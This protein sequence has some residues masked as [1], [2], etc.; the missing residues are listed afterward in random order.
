MQRET[1]ERKREIDTEQIY[2]E[3][4]AKKPLPK[5]KRVTLASIA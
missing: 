5:R 1:K 4:K 3:Q 2:R